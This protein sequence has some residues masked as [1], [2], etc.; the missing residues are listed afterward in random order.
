MSKR[1]PSAKPVEGPFAS[2]GIDWSTWEP[3]AMAN[4]PTTYE[5]APYQLPSRIAGLDCS[6]RTSFCGC[7]PMAA[8]FR[9]RV[10]CDGVSGMQQLKI[11]EPEQ[12]LKK[13]CEATPSPMS[14]EFLRGVFWQRDSSS[15]E[16]LVTFQ[17]ANWT[18]PKL[19]LKQ[20]IYNWTFTPMWL[21]YLINWGRANFWL[22]IEVSPSGKWMLFDD[23]QFCYTV[24]PGDT[25]KDSKG[26][27]LDYIRPGDMM[28]INFDDARDPSKG[29]S[30][31]YLV[32]RVAYLD[33]EGKLNTS[34][35][36]KELLRRA[37]LPSQSACGL[38]A[39]CL[40]EQALADLEIMQSDEQI[41]YT[42]PKQ[43]ELDEVRTA[44]VG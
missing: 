29:V 42:P 12:L 36:Y 10:A 38:F 37:Q 17:E 44:L 6:R 11:S 4:L 22:R 16:T 32:Q 21:S 35:A 25:F 3:L 1:A 40:S 2:D 39:C 19:A 20:Q 27:V 15:I 34:E 28:R 18:S 7:C 24:Q 13:M 41:L 23:D 8:C 26:K 31:Q 30:W 43:Q 9:M 14:P 5:P 33:Q